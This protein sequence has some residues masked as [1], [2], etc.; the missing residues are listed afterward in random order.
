MKAV[1]LIGSL[2]GTLGILTLL[3][4]AVYRLAPRALEA[5]QSGLTPIQW[6]ILILWTIFMGRSEGY[7]GFQKKFSPRTAARVHHLSTHPNLLHTLLAPL[8]GMGY[9]HATKKTKII[10][11]AF[12]IGIICLV[13]LVRLAPQPW[14]GIIDTGVVFFFSWGIIAFLIFVIRAFLNGKPD[15]SP[16]VPELE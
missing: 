2:W 1:G 3:G 13:L 8:F 11:Y 16:E 6:I 5:I 15:H 7:K 4:S 9:F 14:R 12:T 10:A